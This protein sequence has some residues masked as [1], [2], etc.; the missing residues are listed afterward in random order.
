M[1]R[2]LRLVS[3]G[4]AGIPESFRLEFEEKISAN[5]FALSNAE[6]INSSRPVHFKRL[7]WNKKLN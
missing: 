6:D 3:E 7:Y 2:S 4:N 1:L 5:N